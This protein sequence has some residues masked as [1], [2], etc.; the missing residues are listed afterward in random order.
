MMTQKEYNRVL[1]SRD[2]WKLKIKETKRELKIANI[3]AKFH[4]EKSEKKQEIIVNKNSEIESLLKE[5][6]NVKKKAQNMPVSTAIDKKIVVISVFLFIN[7]GISFRS[8]P[9]I[10]KIFFSCLNL[11]IWIPHE[12]TI[13]TWI[14]KLSYYKLNTLS[15]NIFPKNLCVII[16]ITVAKCSTKLL[17]L[18][19]VPINTYKIRNGGLIASEV[20]TIGIFASENWNGCS[21]F[22]KLFEIFSR[23]GFPSQLLMDGGKD[24]KAG[25]NLLKNKLSTLNTNINLIIVNDV[26][27]LFALLLKHKYKDCIEF[28]NFT[29]KLQITSARL[30]QTKLAHLTPPKLRS[31]GRFQGIINVIKWGLNAR[32]FLNIRKR[33]GRTKFQKLLKKSLGWLD[34]KYDF[35]L[36]MESECILLNKIQEILKLFGMD[37]KSYQRCMLELETSNLDSLFKN[38]IIKI[39]KKYIQQ[40]SL[41]GG[42]INVSSDAIESSFG[43]QKFMLERG[44]S[45]DL[46]TSALYLP[47]FTGSHSEEL[48]MDAIKSTKIADIKNFESNMPKSMLKRKLNLPRSCNK[49]YKINLENRRGQKMEKSFNL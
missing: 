1:K 42:S 48:V 24:I 22:E 45:A 38:D 27:H 13:M 40:A 20:E 43:K 23:I 35:L 39:I 14:K 33:K 26:G 10:L 6:E 5:L 49:N 30:R 16:D 9:K 4:Q 44:P 21:I 37:Q 25:V 31:K 17:S 19:A 3:K 36:Q 8:I 15:P 41:L 47:A 28:N 18:L 7:C 2:S 32:Y 29:K 34:N 11:N 12:T 46:A